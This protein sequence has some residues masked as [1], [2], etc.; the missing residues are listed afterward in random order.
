MKANHS[1]NLE[2]HHLNVM[3]KI[4]QAKEMLQQKKKENSDQ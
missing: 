2:T 1:H 3:M 4:Y